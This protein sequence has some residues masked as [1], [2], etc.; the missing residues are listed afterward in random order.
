MWESG[1]VNPTAD[2]LPAIAALYGCS[3]DEL[4]EPQEQEAI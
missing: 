4:Y 3:I 1:S 2:K